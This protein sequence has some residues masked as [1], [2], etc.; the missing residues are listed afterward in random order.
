MDENFGV[1]VPQRVSEEF[2]GVWEESGE[3][4]KRG[5]EEGYL[6]FAYGEGG[7]YV[8]GATHGGEDVGDAQ[9]GEGGVALGDIDV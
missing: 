2:C 6:Q 8:D 4:C 1:L 7:G 3:F 5:V 9:G